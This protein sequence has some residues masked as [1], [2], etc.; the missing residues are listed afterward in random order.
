MKCRGPVENVKVSG[1][2]WQSFW[3]GSSWRDSPETQI[4]K[5]S[6]MV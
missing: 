2:R 3:M 1:L 5:F 6:V 4:P